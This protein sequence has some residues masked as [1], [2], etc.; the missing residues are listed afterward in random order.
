MDYTIQEYYINGSDSTL[1]RKLMNIWVNFCIK[2]PP[3][4][5]FEKKNLRETQNEAKK[6]FNENFRGN[7]CFFDG[8]SR[9]AMFGEGQ[10]WLD[11]EILEFRG[12]KTISLI[13][14]ATLNSSLREGYY[15]LKLLEECFR[16]LKEEYKYQKITWNQNR[17]H[18]QKPFEKMMKTLGGEKINDC[19]HV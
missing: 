13:M 19:W 6:Y 16:R 15:S 7:L 12:Q 10:K 17:A 11:H 5:Q 14:G 2:S 8:E 9:F 4:P 3:L 1:E 18:K